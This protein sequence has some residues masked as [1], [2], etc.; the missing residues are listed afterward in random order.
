M[1][2]RVPVLSKVL[3]F[4]VLA[5]LTRISV[6]NRPRDIEK[7]ANIDSLAIVQIVIV[8]LIV[9]FLLRYFSFVQLSVKYYLRTP[10]I[11]FILIYFVGILSTLW[12]KYPLYSFY[13]ATEST[14][15]IFA[16]VT[17][18]FWLSTGVIHEKYVLSLSILI[19]IL[20][21]IGMYRFVGFNL[22]LKAW[23]SNS[24]TAVAAMGFAYSAGEFLN[25]S[26]F[27]EK[28][29]FGN[30]LIFFLLILI[31]GT[32]SGSF[33]A[34]LFG[35]FTALFVNNRRR[36]S[37]I[38]LVVSVIALIV[39][40][41]SDILLKTIFTGKSASELENLSGR[42]Y[43]WELY[44]QIFLANPVLGEG[45]AVTAR[46][47]PLLPTTNTHNS[48]LAIATGMGIVGIIMFLMMLFA[49][50]KFGI[51]VRNYDSL[52]SKGTFAALVTGIVNSMTI[53]IIGEGWGGSQVVF[54]AFLTMIVLEKFQ[55]E[56]SLCSEDNSRL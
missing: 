39:Y 33:I 52:Y 1:E 30:Y 20:G 18:F 13:R 22:S 26:R 28:R 36:I 2:T 42:M 48:F 35:L 40:G 32:S 56:D 46:I 10:F 15:L 29:R 45:F 37:F 7:F 24:Y 51:S 27:F 23:H 55:N 9:I 47:N 44:W 43:L 49:I 25:R 17:A 21:L 19:I 54:T 34:A 5:H 31:L 6:F 50:F 3:F 53:S 12:S 16:I 11:W 41:Y 8:I 14:I 38:I 4:L